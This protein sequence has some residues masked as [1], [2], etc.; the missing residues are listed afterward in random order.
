MN[1][2]L[3]NVIFGA[4]GGEVAVDSSSKAKQVNIKSYSTEEA[5]M[6]FDTADKIIIVPG[7]GMA[8]AHAQHPVE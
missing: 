3:T 4:V 7:Y 6:I 1:R 8:V 5:A 2:S